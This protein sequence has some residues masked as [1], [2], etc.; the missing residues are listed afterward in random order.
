[1]NKKHERCPQCASPLKGNNRLACRNACEPLSVRTSLNTCYLE[2]DKDAAALVEYVTL[3]EAPSLEGW[4][5]GSKPELETLGLYEGCSA[6][7]AAFTEGGARDVT[8]TWCGQAGI[9]TKTARRRQQKFLARIRELKEHRLVLEFYGFIEANSDGPEVVLAIRE[10]KAA[11]EA[12]EAKAD[13][14]RQVADFYK[15]VSPETQAESQKDVNDFLTREN[16]KDSDEINSR[17]NPEIAT[18]T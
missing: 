11:R 12:R 5:K 8:A 18:A 2:D 16:D 4:L 13:A 9:C 3:L 10:S 7:I 14:A 15:T 6:F 17:R 1:M